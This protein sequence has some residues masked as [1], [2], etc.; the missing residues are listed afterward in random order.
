[1]PFHATWARA[2]FV[3]IPGRLIVSAGASEQ[4][5]LCFAAA[6]ATV[7][8]ASVVF[9]LATVPMSI[10]ASQFGSRLLRGFLSDLQTQLVMGCFAATFLYCISVGL[11]I[12]LN[13]AISQLPFI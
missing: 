8:T 4:R 10:A 5:A 3:L 11:S 9:S 1:M 6:G 12:P 13:A 2:S 7:G